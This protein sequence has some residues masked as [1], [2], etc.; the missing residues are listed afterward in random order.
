M[1]PQW[2]YMRSV[3]ANTPIPAEYRSWKVEALCN[4]CNVKAVVPFHFF[5]AECT[6]CG[7]FNTAI[8]A[9]FRGDGTEVDAQELA[10]QQQN[11]PVEGESQDGENHAYEHEA[12]E[13]V[14]RTL[15]SPFFR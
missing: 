2:D 9:T 3:I 14:D 1:K 6:K 7:G 15:T 11:E 13:W 5:G 10:T 8:T 4:D 12:C